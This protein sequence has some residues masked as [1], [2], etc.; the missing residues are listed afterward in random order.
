MQI[1]KIMAM[2]FNLFFDL[3]LDAQGGN[4]TWKRNL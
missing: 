3:N 1:Q 2:D 4:P